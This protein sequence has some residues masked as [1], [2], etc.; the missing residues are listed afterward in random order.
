MAVEEAESLGCN[1]VADMIA[2]FRRVGEYRHIQEPDRMVRVR[3]ARLGDEAR[4]FRSGARWN[5]RVKSTKTARAHR[6]VLSI[7]VVAVSQVLRYLVDRRLACKF[8]RPAIF[9]IVDVQT[10]CDPLQY[11]QRPR[12]FPFGKEIDMQF[13]VVTYDR[14]GFGGSAHRRS[15]V[16]L[17]A[18]GSSQAAGTDIRQR[19][20]AERRD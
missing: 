17:R 13:E 20:D 9:H 4:C 2:G 5:P 1:N 7:L 11:A 18:P 19:R 8:V 15:G 3:E 16:R 10:C 12:R 6:L 14:S